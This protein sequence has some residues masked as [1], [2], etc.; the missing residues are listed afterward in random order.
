MVIAVTLILALSSAQQQLTVGEHIFEYRILDNGLRVYAIE[1]P[2][3]TTS[4]FMAIA[5]GTRDETAGTTGLAH[6]TEHAMFAGTA[7]TGTDI[8]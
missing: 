7:T 4:V 8:H 3:E 6:L 1:D 2:G 5:A